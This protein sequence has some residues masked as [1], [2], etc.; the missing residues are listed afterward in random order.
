[1]K[2]IKVLHVIGGL[3][4]G[5]AETMLMNLFKHVNHNKFEFH[6]LVYYS[7]KETQD[8]EKEVINLGGKIIH[9]S[10]NNIFN[11]F[12]DTY[13]ICKKEKYDIVHAHTL[14]NS[15][16]SILA[17]RLCNTPMR[18]THSHSTGQMKKE[19]IIIK[20]YIKV[21]K[22]II[23]KCSTHYFACGVQA[24]YYLFGKKLFDKKGLVFKNGIDLDVFNPQKKSDNNQNSKLIQVGCIGSFYRVKNHQ[25][26]IELAEWQKNNN[27]DDV[28]YNLVGK[29]NLEE[30][31]KEQIK[32][33]KVEKYF[34]FYGTRNDI[35][36][37]MNF[38]D[39]LVMPSLYEGIPVTLIEA[40]ACGLP[41]IISNRISTEVD[42]GL[43]LLTI[44]DINKNYKEWNEFIHK[45]YLSFFKEKDKEYIE[46][47][48]TQSGYN[49]KD[50]AIKLE[51][52]YTDGIFKE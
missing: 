33:K 11:M 46:K 2:K 48:I 50:T 43:N 21:S 1:M 42:L 30:H 27:I 23:K 20:I 5:G 36:V 49:I 51:R 10:S 39:I 40:Q 47:V 6:F 31:I 37:V 24:G 38:L 25:F 28:K 18:I 45:K 15:F 29:G 13:N 22:L 34:K 9:V 52:I 35:N 32:E 12:F 26:L 3:N 7:E 44:L 19:N 41:C 4:R 8:Y 16:I 17:S 14:F